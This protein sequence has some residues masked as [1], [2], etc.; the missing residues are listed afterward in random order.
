MERNQGKFC[1][2]SPDGFLKQLIDKQLMQILFY[3]YIGLTVS[4]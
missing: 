4:Q 3:P 2:K 1:L